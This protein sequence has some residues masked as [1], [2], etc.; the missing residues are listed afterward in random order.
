MI[1]DRWEHP[2]RTK[3]DQALV[4]VLPEVVAVIRRDA[5]AFQQYQRE[6]AIRALRIGVCILAA[7]PQLDAAGVSFIEWSKACVPFGRVQ[8]WRF[9][10]IAEK[11]LAAH[12]LQLDDAAK[13]IMGAAFGD[14]KSPGRPSKAVQLALDFTA[15]KSF[16][17]LCDEVGV[18]MRTIGGGS[19]PKP[20]SITPEIREANRRAGAEETLA[21]VIE[22]LGDLVH[23]KKWLYIK[24]GLLH[25]A[26]IEMRKRVQDL[27]TAVKQSENHP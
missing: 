10:R 14:D 16:S 8:V 18:P 2:T 4:N 17:D 11:F 13:Q 19:G 27:E 15:A 9:C 23:G 25:G 22:L 1:A 21:R 7:R 26:L 20:G 24:P 12:K 6:A 5:E 3:D